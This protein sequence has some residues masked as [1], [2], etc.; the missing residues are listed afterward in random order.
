[1]NSRQRPCEF[2]AGLLGKTK[3][4]VFCRTHRCDVAIAADHDGAISLAYQMNIEKESCDAKAKEV[5]NLRDG[6]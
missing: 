6:V 2:S 4:K 3:Y 5:Q 1:M